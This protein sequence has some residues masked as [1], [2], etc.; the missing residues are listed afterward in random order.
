MNFLTHLWL[1]IVLSA[2]LVFILSSL[3]HMVFKYHNSDYRKL[4]NEDEVR[5]AINKGT[6]GP[7]QYIIP[8]VVGPSAMKD[9]ANVKKLTEG[10]SGVLVLRQPGLPQMG[11]YLVQWFIYLLVISF[12]VA[13]V[14]AHTISPGAGS[15]FTFHVIGLVAFLAYAG[16]LA[17][18]AIWRAQPWSATLKEIFDGFLYALVT[19]GTFVLLWP[20]RI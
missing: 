10:P 13:L 8:Y 20:P 14:G 12:L 18:G 7:G 11:S 16:S 2:V 15:H 1:P 19:A 4:G 17:Q 6:P 3:I 9:P 5:A